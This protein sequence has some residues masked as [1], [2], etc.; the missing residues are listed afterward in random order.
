MALVTGTIG[1]GNEGRDDRGDEQDQRLNTNHFYDSYNTINYDSWFNLKAPTDDKSARFRM[2]QPEAPIEIAI[3]NSLIDNY[4][5]QMG[6]QKSQSVVGGSSRQGEEHDTGVSYSSCVA[7][8]VLLV[9]SMAK[10]NKNCYATTDEGRIQCDILADFLQNTLGFKISQIDRYFFVRHKKGDEPSTCV[11][12]A[13]IDDLIVFDSTS[14]MAEIAAELRCRFPLTDGTSDYVGTE[15][16]IL[17][18]DTHVH[19]K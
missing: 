17:N 10:H 18:D 14:A 3:L 19:Q 15:N 11:I 1:S 5:N 16:K 7:S 6:K 2:H 8:P 12:L 13:Y 9:F 4:V